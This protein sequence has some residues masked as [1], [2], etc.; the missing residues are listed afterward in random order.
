M[1]VI[2]TKTIQLQGN[3]TPPQD[4]RT[5]RVSRIPVKD[6]RIPIKTVTPVNQIPIKVQVRPI[7]SLNKINLKDQQV[8]RSFRHLL[9][10]TRP[11]FRPNSKRGE[12]QAAS[13]AG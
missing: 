7:R 13:L 12:V 1:L 11:Q 9:T 3:Q 5:A 10:P 6:S 4:N 2:P 8:L